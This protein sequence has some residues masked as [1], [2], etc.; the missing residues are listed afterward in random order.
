VSYK[1]A[2]WP[3]DVGVSTMQ[4][5]CAIDLNTCAFGFLE[6]DIACGVD[7]PWL[8]HRLTFETQWQVARCER[9]RLPGCRRLLRIMGKRMNQ[10][11]A[12]KAI[13]RSGSRANG[14][15]SG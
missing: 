1:R 15:Q 3:P 6:V 9:N 13:G 8:W 4:I 2:Q 11:R 14:Q 7:L 10:C 5:A 12:Y